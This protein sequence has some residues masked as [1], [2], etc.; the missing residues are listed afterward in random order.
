[1]PKTK[2]RRNTNRIPQYNYS[3]PGYYFVT[4]CTQNRQQIFG[5][6]VNNQMILN[7]AGNMIDTVLN[8]IPKNYVG[9]DLD[10]HIVM[11]NHVHII[12]EITEYVGAAPCGRPNQLSNQNKI[13]HN[14]QAQGPVPTHNLSLSDIIHRFKTLTT[15]K[16]INGVKINNWIPFN[17]HLWQR[18]FHDHIIRNEK[19][20]RN[21][22][23]YISNNPATWDQDVENPNR[24]GNI[25]ISV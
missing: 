9:I 22:R 8:Q 25:P 12:I 13:I 10:E 1:M 17:R 21:I 11:P 4:I 15:K 24:A 6:I 19:S 23:K 18:S 7:D 14:G 2:T 5:T 16:Y 3:T 20:L